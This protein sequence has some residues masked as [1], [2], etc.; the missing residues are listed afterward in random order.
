MQT[1]TDA[2]KNG[3]FH[4]V[5]ISFGNAGAIVRFSKE[6]KITFCAASWLRTRTGPVDRVFSIVPSALFGPAENLMTMD[7]LEGEAAKGR[8]RL[9]VYQD[10][11]LEAM[12]CTNSEGGYWGVVYMNRIGQVADYASTAYR[13]DHNWR[14]EKD[15]SNSIPRIDQFLH[16]E[17]IEVAEGMTTAWPIL[18]AAAALFGGQDPANLPPAPHNIPGDLRTACEAERAFR[19][20]Q[21]R[22]RS[23]SP[24]KAAEFKSM[25]NPAQ[26]AAFD[27]LL[28]GRR[29]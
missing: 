15:T 3:P 10:N 17:F 13:L 27:D 25:L 22:A 4:R 1:N 2:R 29:S 24:E 19:D 5:G 28:E 14:L 21:R 9:D 11:R 6:H 26:L 16:S 20:K 8:F 12:Y 23:M 18:Y 7:A